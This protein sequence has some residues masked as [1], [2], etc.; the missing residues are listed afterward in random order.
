MHLAAGADRAVDVVNRPR[1]LV[2][3]DH[4]ALIT[5]I[6]VMGRAEFGVPRC[7]D[8]DYQCCGTACV[9]QLIANC[10]EW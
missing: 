6:E 9:N 5:D 10:F 4:D 8:P 2:V 1:P 7:A 3:D